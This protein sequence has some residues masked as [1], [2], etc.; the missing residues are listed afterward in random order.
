MTDRLVIFVRSEATLSFLSLRAFCGA[1]GVAI[2]LLVEKYFLKN[3][4]C[5]GFPSGAL[6]SMGKGFCW[7]FAF[8]FLI[9]GS[10][11]NFHFE[12]LGL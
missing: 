9:I 3:W 12:T 5:H 1:E 7:L 2:S 10:F 6:A 11:L 4:V 8:Y